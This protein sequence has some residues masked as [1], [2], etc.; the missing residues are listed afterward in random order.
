MTRPVTRMQPKEITMKATG[1]VRVV[2]GLQ[3]LLG[4]YMLALSI[5][6]YFGH[7]FE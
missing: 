2:A 6:S 1:W 5:Q 4:V 3:S 7:L